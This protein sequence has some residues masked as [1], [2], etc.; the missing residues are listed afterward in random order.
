MEE[1]VELLVLQRDFA[2][3]RAIKVELEVVPGNK[4]VLA[5]DLPREEIRWHDAAVEG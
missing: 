2:S 4:S 5:D 1:L 3:A